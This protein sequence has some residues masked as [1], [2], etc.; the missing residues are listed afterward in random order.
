MDVMSDALS[1][2]LK[3]QLNRRGWSRRRLADEAGVAP[4]TTARIVRGEGLPSPDTLRK[5]AEALE[6]N[7][8]YLL[9]LAGYLEDRPKGL[10]N[11]AVIDLARQIE[12]LPSPAQE[13]A[14]EA[15]RAML[16][17]IHTLLDPHSSED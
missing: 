4:D 16:D 10:H 12:E 17:T 1:D 6:V 3:D 15:V 13:K 14:I 8:A 7:E 2:F 5:I 9:R 11:A